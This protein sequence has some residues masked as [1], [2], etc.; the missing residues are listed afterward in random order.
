MIQTT[1]LIFLP[2]LFPAEV[3]V[4]WLVLFHRIKLAVL[5][6]GRK[7]FVGGPRD[8]LEHKQGKKRLYFL[9]YRKDLNCKILK[10]L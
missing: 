8:P 10:I 2:V 5:S 7:T 9:L 4:D 1:M 6:S 3:L